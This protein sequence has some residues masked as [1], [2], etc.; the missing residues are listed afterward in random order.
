MILKLKNL[1]IDKTGETKKQVQRTL[2]DSVQDFL[3]SDI[4]MSIHGY[5]NKNQAVSKG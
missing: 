5:I 2:S 3:L 4:L 1:F